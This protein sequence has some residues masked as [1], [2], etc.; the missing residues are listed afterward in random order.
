[1]VL[2]LMI[3]CIQ[4]RRAASIK[5]RIETLMMNY[6]RSKIMSGRRAASIK[7]RI[8]TML[9]IGK[10][11]TMMGRRAASIKTRI[12]TIDS[13]SWTPPENQVAGRHPSKQGLKP[14]NQTINRAGSRVAGRHPSKQGL[15]LIPLCF[16]LFVG[17]FVAGRHPSKQGLKLSSR[18]GERFLYARRRAA[19]I[20]TRIETSVG[21]RTCRRS[22]ESQGG[23][24]QN[25]D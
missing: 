9:Q 2:M 16:V 25:K 23:I 18:C 11:K 14:R 8:E 22:S 17:T 20:K 3:I 4:S 10:E 7:T 21:C 1:M 6:M 19:S 15:K 13:F 5:T 12:E 24:H